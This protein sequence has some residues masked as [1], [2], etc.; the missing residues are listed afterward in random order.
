MNLPE[1]LQIILIVAVLSVTIIIFINTI[2]LKK[3]RNLAPG[4][5]DSWK[6]GVFYYNP[7]DRRL[8]LPKRSGLGITVNFANPLSIVIT[9]V[10]VVLIAG[11]ASL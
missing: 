2:I 4:E 7:L 11:L 9:G 10:L 5:A 1:N 3:W 8:F 6:R